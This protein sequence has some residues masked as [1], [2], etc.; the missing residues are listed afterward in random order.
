LKPANASEKKNV[1]VA[2]LLKKKMYKKPNNYW[3]LLLFNSE[4]ITGPLKPIS[5]KITIL[6]EN[7]KSIKL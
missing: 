2:K 5:G 3:S 4:L 6:H 1:K 7:K